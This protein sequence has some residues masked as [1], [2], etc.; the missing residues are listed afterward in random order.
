MANA[1][2]RRTQGTTDDDFD[3]LL[4]DALGQLLPARHIQAGDSWYF[5]VEGSGDE[6]RLTITRSRAVVSIPDPDS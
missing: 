6:A 3:M 5:R 2:R 4:S 1:R